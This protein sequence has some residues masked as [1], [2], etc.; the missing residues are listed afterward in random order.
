MGQQSNSR[1]GE[2]NHHVGIHQCNHLFIYC[3]NSGAG[4]RKPG[5][6]IRKNNTCF[7]VYYFRRH[8]LSVICP[9]VCRFFSVSRTPF[10]TYYPWLDFSTDLNL[11]PNANTGVKTASSQ[12][13]KTC[14]HTR[15]SKCPWALFGSEVGFWHTVDM[16]LLYTVFSDVQTEVLRIK[17]QPRTEQFDRCHVHTLTQDIHKQTQNSKGKKLPLSGSDRSV[18]A[19]PSMAVWQVITASDCVGRDLLGGSYLTGCTLSG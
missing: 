6:D 13:G 18:P 16:L 3:N 12:T 8:I 9:R 10:E 2:Q 11:L 1:P 14:I 4:I 17:K 15:T 19:Y 7:F 5:T